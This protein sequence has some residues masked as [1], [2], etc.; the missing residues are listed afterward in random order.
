MDNQLSLVNPEDVVSLH[1]A[2]DLLS[3][4]YSAIIHLL[5]TRPHI[6]DEYTF[7]M[8]YKGRRKTVIT[9]RGLLVLGQ[10][11]DSD[12]GNAT[13]RDLASPFQ[14]KEDIAKRI[15]AMADDPIISMRL[16]QLQL[17]REVQM[18][19]KRTTAVEE[20]LGDVNNA[21]VT[22]L[23]RANLNDRVRGLAIKMNLTFASAWRHLHNHIGKSSVNDYEFEDYAKSM[24][25]MK[26]I[27]KQAKLPWN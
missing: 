20:T 22:P 19:D 8:R 25:Y 2:A 18:L 15:I 14:Q 6:R 7:K 11:K 27:Y 10:T 17:E 1:E 23:Q 12:R 3:I 16:K 9:R 4:T 13:K 24:K 21:E 5:K 26:A